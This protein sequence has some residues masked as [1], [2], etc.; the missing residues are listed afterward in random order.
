LRAKPLSIIGH[1]F[2]LVTLAI[3]LRAIEPLLG[4]GE[5][6]TD[7]VVLSSSSA[8][9]LA[10]VPSGGIAPGAW[11]LETGY[12]RQYNLSEFDQFFLAAAVRK[13]KLVVSGEIES[14]GKS[15]MYSE[16][17]GRFMLAYRYDSLSVGSNVSGQLLQFGNGYENLS[18]LAIGFG[19][20]YR[21][22]KYYFAVTGDNLNSPKYIDSAPVIGKLFGVYGEYSGKKQY[23]IL[24][25]AKMEEDQDTRFGFGQ[26]INLTDKGALV[27]GIQTEPFKYGAGFELEML[28]GRLAYSFSIHPVLGYSHVMSISVGKLA[29]AARGGDDFE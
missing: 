2:A 16:L 6:L 14:F 12:S 17:T 27:W 26:R 8:S 24:A 13:G 3:P 15:E 29:R 1:L 19:I 22:D 9:M 18:A 21:R 23:A 5:G 7:N 11:L 4:Q 25:H 28:G 20:S 10:R